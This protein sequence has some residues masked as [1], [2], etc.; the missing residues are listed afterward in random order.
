VDK[1]IFTWSSG[2][3][4]ALALHQIRE[5][6]RPEV[7]GLITTVTQE[8]QRVSMHGVRAE[9]LDR[10][11]K[12]L[13]LPLDKMYINTR[14]ANA[15]YERKMLERLLFHKK[16]GVSAVVFGDIFL[17]DVRK[18]REDNLK[19]AGLSALFPL[20]KKDTR[21]LANAFIELGFKAVATCV[22]TRVL[23]KEFCGREFDASFLSDLPGGVD[24]CGENGEFHTFAYAGP[25]F[26]EKI[27][28]EKGE[29]VLRDNRFYFCDLVP[30]P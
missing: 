29:M 23:D 7:T 1:A 9:L 12:A 5:S 8:Y 14:A 17:E 3:D 6:G 25:V 26:K 13:G 30:T 28:F 4:S 11:A 27:G 18:Y 16:Q 24:P 2:K 10:Q 15:E 22:D 19:K 20:W 21:D